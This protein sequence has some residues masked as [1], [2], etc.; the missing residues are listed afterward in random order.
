MMRAIRFAAQLRFEIEH[1][2]FESIKRNADRI[3]IIS[4]ERISDELNKI[5]LSKKPSIGFNLLYDSGLLHL[6]FPE[7]AALHGVEIIDEKAHKDNFYHTLMVLDNICLDTDDLWLRWAALLHDIGDTLGSYNHPDIAAAILKPF[8]GEANH[9]MVA[10]HGIFQGYYF[11]H[12]LGLDRDMRETYRDHPHFEHTARF[13]HR[14]DQNAFDPSYDT[15]PLEAFE[16]MVKRLFAAPKNSIY[17]KAL[18]EKN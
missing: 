1:E 13:C 16:P 10:N 8:V 6:V 9:W 4:F 17:L 3:K 14:H 5:M 15:M 12:H 2:T 11:F 7:L 18:A